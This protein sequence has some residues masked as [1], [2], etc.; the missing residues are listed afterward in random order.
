MEE[1][2]MQAIYKARPQ[3]MSRHVIFRAGGNVHVN[4]KVA[5]EDKA[6]E[7]HSSE[8]DG[9][10]IEGD[11]GGSPSDLVERRRRL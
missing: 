1:K 7:E 5:V 9:E 11:D 8:R 2:S 6:V 10:R 3:T 4:N